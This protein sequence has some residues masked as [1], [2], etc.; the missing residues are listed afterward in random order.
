MSDGGR[1]PTTHPGPDPAPVCIVVH[2]CSQ[3]ERWDG[4][5]VNQEAARE[6]FGADE[7]FWMH[8]VRWGGVVVGLWSGQGR[9]GRARGM[10]RAT[11]S[12]GVRGKLL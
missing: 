5:T 3:R 7:V 9:A 11:K 4:A 1:N 10:M 6:V 12:H 2:F 8:E